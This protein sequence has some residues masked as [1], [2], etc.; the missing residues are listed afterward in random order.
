MPTDVAP[1]FVIVTLGVSDLER[2]IRF[3]AGL[4][5][6]E[7]GD[8]ENGIVWFRTSGTWLG[9]FGYEALAEDTSLDA[10]P[11]DEQPR[12]RGVTFA[13]NLPSEDAVDLAFVRVHDVGGTI[14]KPP[15]HTDWGGYSGYFADP[16]GFIWEI[17]HNPGF[18]L[19]DQGRIEIP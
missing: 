13:V 6:E 17:A 15:A 1:N 3:Y 12:Y 16:D 5:W 8:A 2:S 4:G 11:P 10:V 7:R 14:V 19:D 9:L 18:A